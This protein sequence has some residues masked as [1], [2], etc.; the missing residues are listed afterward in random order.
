MR[1]AAG[2]QHSVTGRIPS[3]HCHARRGSNAGSYRNIRT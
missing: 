2:A 3:I 1:C